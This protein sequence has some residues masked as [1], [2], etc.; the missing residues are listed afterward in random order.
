MVDIKNTTVFSTDR[1][2]RKQKEKNDFAWYKEKADFYE[3]EANISFN[4]NGGEIDEYKRMK[5]NYDL[6]NNIL[7]LSDFSYVCTPF[8]AEVGELPA[9]MVK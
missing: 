6:F 2:T 9:R 1:L 7:D 4:R 5:V 3:T 8:G